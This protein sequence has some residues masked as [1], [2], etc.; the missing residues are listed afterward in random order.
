MSKKFAD[1]FPDSSLLIMVGLIV[2]VVLSLAGVDSS[3]FSLDSS[4]FFLLS[5]A[6]HCVRRR[7]LYA[8]S[9]VLRQP[10]FYPRVC[11]ARHYLEHGHHWCVA[12]CRLLDC[13]VAFCVHL[14]F[15]ISGISLW[16]VGL[17]GIFTAETPLLHVLLFS[18][19]ISAVDPVAV[20]VVFEE[21]HVN[22][23]LYI[24]VFGESLLNDAV[25]VVSYFTM[26][27]V[28]IVYHSLCTANFVVLF[29]CCT[30]CSSRFLRLAQRI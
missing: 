27:S 18:S 28:I 21:I 1:I 15:G 8:Q 29:R 19:L 7:L 30:K 3:T 2:G 22:E 26:R 24:T 20:I 10:R 14:V 17:S 23:M 12:N 25:T 13:A 5:A 16:A 11:C 6:A 9:R 4:I